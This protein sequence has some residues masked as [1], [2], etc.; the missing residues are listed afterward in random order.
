MDATKF[1]AMLSDSIEGARAEGRP[2][3]V[4]LEGG[5]YDVTAGI[6]IFS[7]NSLKSVVCTTE[8]LIRNYRDRVRAILGIL[9]NDLGQSCKTTCTEKPQT[10]NV[11]KFEELP[12]ELQAILAEMRYFKSEKLLV[13][14]ERAAKNRGIKTLRSKKKCNDKR[15]KTVDG[16]IFFDSYDGGKYLVGEN[17]GEV[18]SAKC[19]TIMAQHYTDV[20]DRISRRFVHQN[21][22]QILVDFSMMNDRSQVSAGAEIALRGLIDGSSPRTIMNVLWGD[23]AGEFI[24]AHLQSNEEYD[25]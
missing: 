9:V 16:K 11:E 8:S 14:S 12:P 1:E 2:V 21:Y 18:W 7:E 23:E 25:E 10:R 5:H 6:T 22:P 15:F 20:S 13:M 4:Y 17:H 19:P 3:A 24:T